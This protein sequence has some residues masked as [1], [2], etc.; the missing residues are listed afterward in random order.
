MTTAS[1]SNSPIVI[2]ILKEFIGGFR[3]ERD[4][5][6]KITARNLFSSEVRFTLQHPVPN[7]VSKQETATALGPKNSANRLF[8]SIQD[9]ADS[10]G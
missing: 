3:Y 5:F 7:G 2:Q 10:K 8:F 6:V 4:Y 9:L 1:Y